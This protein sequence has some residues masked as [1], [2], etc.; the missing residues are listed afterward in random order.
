MSR[1]PLEYIRHILDEIDYIHSEIPGLD[2]ESFNRNPTLKRAFVRSPEVIGE[3]TKK[4]P[5]ELRD[6]QPQVEWRK[7]AGM[8]DR[9]VHAYFGVDCAI[10]RDVATNRLGP[11][12]DA[13][14]E[15][16]ESLDDEKNDERPRSR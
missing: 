5:M 10:V 8:R 6:R 1:L 16:M 14:R 2:Y 15:I 12:R 7:V 13:L 11:L 3:A 9:L 4:V